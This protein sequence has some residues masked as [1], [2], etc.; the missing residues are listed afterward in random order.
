MPDIQ[1][2]YIQKFAKCFLIFENP[3]MIF[4]RIIFIFINYISIYW[5]SFKYLVEILMILNGVYDRY[6][7]IRF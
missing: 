7:W 6:F 1:Y 4:E 5:S 3:F 2:V